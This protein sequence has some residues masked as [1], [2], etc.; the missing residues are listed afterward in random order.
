MTRYYPDNNKKFMHKSIISRNI[1]DISEIIEKVN[2]KSSC[3][4]Q[5]SMYEF[6][7]Y[8]REL[9]IYE[10][11]ITKEIQRIG[12]KNTNNKY[13]KTGIARDDVNLHNLVTRRNFI[14][15]ITDAVIEMK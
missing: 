14:A 7:Y 3:M 6:S 11:E 1:I 15:K 13:G 8:Y 10:E 9:V 2:N 12:S 5:M 4:S